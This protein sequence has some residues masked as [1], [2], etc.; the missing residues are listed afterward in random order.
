MYI[1]KCMDLCFLFFLIYLQVVIFSP[2]PKSCFKIVC[3]FVCVLFWKFFIHPLESPAV[4]GRLAYYFCFPK[5]SEHHAIWQLPEKWICCNNNCF[6]SILTWAWGAV[7]VREGTYLTDLSG[8]CQWLQKSFT[9]T[10]F[11]KNPWIKIV[12]AMYVKHLVIISTTFG[13]LVQCFRVCFPGMRSQKLW[14]PN[15]QEI[16]IENSK[17]KI[18]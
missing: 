3:V 7:S 14:R 11:S 13:E 16:E 1:Q 5:S 4:T 12:T 17:L 18:P 9:S 2:L 15:L 8:I 6:L 10:Q